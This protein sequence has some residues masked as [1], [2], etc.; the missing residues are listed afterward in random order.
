MAA[1]KGQLLKVNSNNEMK[2]FNFA[3]GGNEISRGDLAFK[4]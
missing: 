2:K 3:D 4:Q 1:E